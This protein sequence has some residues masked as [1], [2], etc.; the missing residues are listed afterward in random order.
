METAAN[1]VGASAL[2]LTADPLKTRIETLRRSGAARR[3]HTRRPWR[4]LSLR[5]GPRS[6]RRAGGGALVQAMAGEDDESPA[7]PKLNGAI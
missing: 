4:D 3:G 2:F 1:R 6:D 7:Q 5:P